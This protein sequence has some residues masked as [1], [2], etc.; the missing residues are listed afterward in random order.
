MGHVYQVWDK[1][2]LT[3]DDFLGHC[4]VPAQLLRT[5]VHSY[6]EVQDVWKVLDGGGHAQGDQIWLFL[7][8]NDGNLGDFEFILAIFDI[9]YL[10]TLATLQTQWPR[11]I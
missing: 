4:L 10:V 8:C 5:A 9:F 11:F 6:G 1:D 3:E 7:G 2:V